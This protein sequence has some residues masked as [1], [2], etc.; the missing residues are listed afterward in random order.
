[1]ATN[2]NNAQRCYL[3]GVAAL[4]KLIEARIEHDLQEENSKLLTL[5]AGASTA[6]PLNLIP[7][8]QI[9]GVE[10][11]IEKKRVWLEKWRV[12]VWEAVEQAGGNASHLKQK[13]LEACISS[14]AN[15]NEIARFLLLQ[16][17]VLAPMYDEFE[18]SPKNITELVAPRKQALYLSPLVN[19][20]EKVGCDIYNN[21]DAFIKR[22]YN[23]SN[24]LPSPIV[25]G[26]AFAN[27]FLLGVS[28]IGGLVGRLS[29]L[30]GASA[31]SH[32]LAVLGGG[33]IASGGL[34]VAGGIKVIGLGGFTLGCLFRAGISELTRLPEHTLTMSMCRVS[35]VVK[36]LSES[37]EPRA[38]EY[39]NSVIDSF[40][41]T[42]QKLERELLTTQM[43]HDKI[44]ENKKALHILTITYDHLF[45][46]KSGS[47]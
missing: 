28:P 12:N 34:G 22:T 41:S 5:K 4:A 43:P 13:P 19:L 7:R 8:T 42:K 25:T 20:P 9:P 38:M 32:G 21:A 33:S 31:V 27:L 40:L 24:M 1:M 2:E 47:R 17:A 45:E 46:I 23:S 29:G 37:H 10:S 3:N 11:A 15:N 18:G 36:Y 26:L 6:T 39:M 44:V 30:S 16:E 35:N 14:Y